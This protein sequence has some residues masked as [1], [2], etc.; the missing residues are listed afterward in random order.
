[1]D[2][3]D[4]CYVYTATEKGRALTYPNQRTRV[5]TGNGVTDLLPFEISLKDDRQVDNAGINV[6]WNLKNNVNYRG[7]H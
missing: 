3:F 4:S 5:E 1:M 7:L 2:V 6:Q